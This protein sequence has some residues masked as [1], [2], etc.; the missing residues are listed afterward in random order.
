M[1][2]RRTGF[3]LIELLVVIAIIAVLMGILMP[4]LGRVR[5]AAKRSVCAN[6]MRQMGIAL[7]TY[8]QAYDLRLPYYDDIAHPYAVYRGDKAPYQT[9]S[10]KLIPMKM[11]VLYETHYIADPRVFYCP[12]NID[13]WLKFES[14]T[15]PGPWGTLPQVYNEESGSNQWVRMGYTYLPIDPRARTEPDTGAPA[16]TAR[17]LD[18]L[19]PYVPYMVDIIN[20]LDVISHMRQGHAAVNALYKDGHVTLCNETRVFDD[21]SWALHSD[22]RMDHVSFYHRILQLIGGKRVPEL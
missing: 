2:K 15:N 8:A 5:E 7:S 10:G 14:Y 6:Q 18:R 19:D 12:S 21:P 3:T 16:E 1:K 9:E 11:A 13:P 22:D 20:H 17:Q 4:V